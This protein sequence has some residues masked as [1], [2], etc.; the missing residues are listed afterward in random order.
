LNSTS[1]LQDFMAIVDPELVTRIIAD[2]AQEVILP[3]FRAL[4]PQ[5]VR[6]KRPGDL[7]TVADIEA[8]DMLARRLGELLPGSIVVGEEAASA[9]VSLQ[10]ALQGSAPVWVVDPIDGTGNFVRGNAQFGVIVA[11]VQD[12]R[13]RQGWIHD[14]LLFR[15]SY[16][17]LGEGAWCG[18][19]RLRVEG[20]VENGANG[21]LVG[22]A[23]WR[24]RRRLERAGHYLRQLGSAAH[25]YLA[26]LE[27]SL[28]FACYHRL[29]PWDHAAGVLMHLEAGGVSGLL[30]GGD[31]QPVPQAGSLLMA[32]NEESWRALRAMFA[33]EA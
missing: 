12:K 18:S 30:H 32:A 4:A 33:G 26:L 28:D 13:T 31:Y 27:G 14:P 11:L 20:R 8:E 21:G 5:D 22:A 1:R 17:V 7:V 23:A 19:R 9:D 6:E 2:V 16:A 29:H 24:D 3:R 15:T 10:A 25:E